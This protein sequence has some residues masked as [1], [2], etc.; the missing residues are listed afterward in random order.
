[1]SI[2]SLVPIFDLE[3]FKSTAFDLAFTAEILN[4]DGT[5]QDPQVFYDLTGKTIA[6]H[7][8]GIFRDLFTLVSGPDN[9][10]GSNITIATD[11]TLGQFGLHLSASELDRVNSKV[12]Y[13][14][15]AVQE[16]DVDDVILVRGTIT[17]IPFDAEGDL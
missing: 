13:Y 6:I 8:N 5:S 4:E 15:M 10:L 14:H 11:H 3:M 2:P 9:S 1:M 17:I 7:I 16:T 12:G